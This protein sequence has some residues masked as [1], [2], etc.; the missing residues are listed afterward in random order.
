MSVGRPVAL[1]AVAAS[2]LAGASYL[3]PV[4]AEEITLQLWSRADRSGP[5]RPANILSAAEAVNEMLK[6]AG[7]ENTVK[8]EVLENNATDF[9]QDPL[10]MLQA[11]A[12]ER[13]PDFYVAAHEWIGE[14]AKSGYAMNMEQF[15]KANPCAFADVI[16]VFWESV[17]VQ[18]FEGPATGYDADALD[19]LKAFSVGEGPDLYVAPHEWIGEFARSGYAIDIE[20][21]VTDNPW[22]FGHAIPILS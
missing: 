10:D 6:A 4:A 21:L 20:R 18:V 13:C 12:V 8:A 16:P 19:I 17:K 1:G 9:D 7:S 3:A 11:C 22:A 14:F 2:L 15:V 5:M